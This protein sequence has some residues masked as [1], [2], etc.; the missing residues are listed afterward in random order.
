M[1][2]IYGTS[3]HDNADLG[4]VDLMGTDQNDAIYGY[5]G[6]D[7]I[8]GRQGDDT[9][10]GGTGHNTI[11]G[12]EGDDYVYSDGLT[13]R[14]DGGNGVDTLNVA[15][16][17]QRAYLDLAAGKGNFGAQNLT[18]STAFTM[19]NF[20]NLVTGAGADAIF[21]SAAANVIFSGGGADVV[22]GRGGNDSLYGGAGDDELHGDAGN[23]HLDG[24]D[25]KDT[26]RGGAGNDTLV[27]GRGDDTLI[28]GDGF[29]TATWAAHA[30]AVTVDMT[31]ATAISVVKGVYEVDSLIDIEKIVGSGYG[32][33]VYAGA[34]TEVDG[35]AGD[36]LILSGS[37]ANRLVGGAGVDTLSYASSNAGVNVSLATGSAW[38]GW[39]K[40]DSI[41]GFENLTG[42]GLAD[43]L[44]GNALANVLIGG[45]GNDVLSGGGGAD[46][47]IGGAGADQLRGGGGADV[48]RFFSTSESP[49]GT[50][51]HDWIMDFQKGIDKIDL[52]GVDAN[53]HASGAQSFVKLIGNS[54]PEAASDFTAG[55]I[56]W[57]QTGGDTLIDIN[58]SDNTTNGLDA[59]EMQI[60]LDGL[61]TITLSDFLL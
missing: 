25:G 1:A 50:E 29:D 4:G 37:G 19:A 22:R 40:G 13:G 5:G 34:T 31:G 32:D 55:T 46:V 49:A 3:G 30:A 12:G 11:F 39:A 35:G 27:G 9:I 6:D 60:R 47:I 16:L 57:R 54:N 28:G 42:S 8:N 24:G 38:G 2:F 59:P 17:S 23:D 43:T 58:I 10:W 33:R 36:D 61:Y 45:G 7:Y 44:T 51:N 15:S 53:A 21:G 26:L 20:E 48:F 41:T 56:N 18:S 14:Y 52:R